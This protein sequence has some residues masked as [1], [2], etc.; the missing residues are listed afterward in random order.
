[1]PKCAEEK[2]GEVK[3][4][5]SHYFLRLTLFLSRIRSVVF[6]VRISNAVKG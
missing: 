5:Q 6:P 1:M 2:A 4:G 3:Q